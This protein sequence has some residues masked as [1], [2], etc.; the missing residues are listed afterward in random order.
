MLSWH[1]VGHKPLRPQWED[2]LSTL[3]EVIHVERALLVGIRA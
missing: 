3:G 2:H 1:G